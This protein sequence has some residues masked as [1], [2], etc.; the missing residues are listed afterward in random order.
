MGEDLIS[1]KFISKISSLLISNKNNL[2]SYLKIS[3]QNSELSLII[4][5]DSMNN[6]IFL[7]NSETGL[8]YYAIKVFYYICVIN[9][10]KNLYMI[11]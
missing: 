11:I 1:A 2:F 8:A 6:E 10:E 9:E 4:N 3:Q 5:E 7:L